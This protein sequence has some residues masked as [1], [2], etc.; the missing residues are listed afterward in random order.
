MESLEK[1]CSARYGGKQS[2]ISRVNYATF[3]DTSQ[4]LVTVYPYLNWPNNWKDL[5]SMVARCSQEMRIVTVSWT[6]PPNS[7]YKLNT[8]GSALNDLGKIGGGGVLTDHLGSLVYA[9][10]VPLGMVSNNQVEDQA[11]TFWIN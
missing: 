8:D 5:I 4:L 2:S 10:A 11:A 3:K 6:R 1:Q 7:I 9:F